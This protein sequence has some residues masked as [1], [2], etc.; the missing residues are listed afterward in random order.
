[1]G[2]LCKIYVTVRQ[3]EQSSLRIHRYRRFAVK[4]S[5]LAAL[6]TMSSSQCRDDYAVGKLTRFEVMFR[7]YLKAR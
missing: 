6:K 1:M 3:F 7:D 4:L 2:D 5:S